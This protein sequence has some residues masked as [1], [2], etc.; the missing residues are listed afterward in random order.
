MLGHL[1]VHAVGRT[2]FGR[3]MNAMMMLLFVMILPIGSV[4]GFSI[5]AWKHF[6][7]EAECRRRFGADW[8]AQYQSVDGNLSQSRG[9]VALALAAAVANS[10]VGVW[11]YKLLIPALGGAEYASRPRRRKSSRRSQS[12]REV[13]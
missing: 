12:Q 8:K 10:F 9:K 5:Y 1:I 4:A 3:F 13:N 11:L 7:K 6:A 2:S